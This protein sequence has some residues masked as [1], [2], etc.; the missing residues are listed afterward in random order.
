M[1][2]T[3]IWDNTSR[4]SSLDVD[5]DDDVD[6]FLRDRAAKSCSSKTDGCD[7]EVDADADG[8]WL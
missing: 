7:A 6:C 1:M 2:G 5:V 8:I 3:L 4:K